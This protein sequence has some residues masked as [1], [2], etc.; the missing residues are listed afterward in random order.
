MK[1]L[2]ELQ[3]IKEKMKDYL[4][5]NPNLTFV[6]WQGE[7]CGP[8]IQKNPHR[9]KEN[10]LFMFHWTDNTGRWNII[11]AMKYLGLK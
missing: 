8:T 7:L 9:L 6:C 10:H 1:S 2:A 3:P 4:D 5:A 11:D